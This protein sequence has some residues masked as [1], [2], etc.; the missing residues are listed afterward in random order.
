MSAEGLFGSITRRE[1]LKKGGKAVGVVGGAFI[2][3]AVDGI[4]IRAVARG[5]TAALASYETTTCKDIQ[6]PANGYIFKVHECETRDA[7][8]ELIGG[9]SSTGTE[10]LEPRPE[11]YS[12]PNKP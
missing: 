9:S 6:V 12:N 1:F 5:A 3:G 11:P 7:K 8:G 4:I 10:D 2:V